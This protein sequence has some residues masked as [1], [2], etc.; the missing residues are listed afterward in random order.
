MMDRKRGHIRS[1]SCLYVLSPLASVNCCIR[2]Q[3]HQYLCYSQAMAMG[4]PTMVINWSGN[5]EFAHTHSLF[6]TPTLSLSH[7]N[8]PSLKH[9]LS[10]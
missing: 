5:T 2:G 7:T 8:S 9:F 6:L 1:T 4:V 3:T 10:H